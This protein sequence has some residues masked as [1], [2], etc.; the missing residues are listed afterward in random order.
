MYSKQVIK[1][2]GVQ[3]GRYTAILTWLFSQQQIKQNTEVADDDEGRK[4]VKESIGTQ[5]PSKLVRCYS[6]THPPLA[7][8]DWPSGW[9]GSLAWHLTGWLSNRLSDWWTSITI[10]LHYACWW[11]FL[12]RHIAFLTWLAAYSP[13]ALFASILL[14]RFHGAFLLKNSTRLGSTL[15]VVLNPHSSTF[16]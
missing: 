6:A 4:V 14:S 15:L 5:T 13:N 16:G 11:S 8:F 10:S 3:A 1:P 9:T 7:L 12:T 2:P